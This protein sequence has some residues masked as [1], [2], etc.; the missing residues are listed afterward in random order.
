MKHVA[1]LALLGFAI[2]SLFRQDMTAFWALLILSQLNFMRSDIHEMKED[3]DSLC[4]RDIVISKYEFADRVRSALVPMSEATLVCIAE[5]LQVATS[6]IHR[7]ANGTSCPAP[8]L[9]QKFLEAL[10]R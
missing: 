8:R 4:R 1:A 10:E 7:W 6:T 9:R 5:E 3:V 2:F